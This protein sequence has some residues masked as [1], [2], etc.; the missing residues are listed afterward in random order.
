MNSSRFSSQRQSRLFRC[1]AWLQIALQFIFPLLSAT[2][3]MAMAQS[4]TNTTSPPQN[5]QPLPYSTTLNSAALALTSGDGGG[6]AGMAES[7]A[8]GYASSSVQQWLSQF[9][10]AHVQ[11]NVDDNGNWDNSAFDFLAP[12]YD[13]Q[14][15]VLFT[16]LGLRAPDGRITGNV[17]MG[18]RTF[19]T[20]NWMFGGN[21]FFDDDFTGKN[22]RVGVGA[23]AWT[24]NLKLSAN[25]YVGTTDWHQ[26]RDFDDYNEKP[27]DGYDVRAEGYLPAYPQLGAKVMYEQYYGDQVAL[28][29]KDHLQSDPSAVT[30][31]LNYTPV[32]LITAGVDYKRGQDS[33]DETR[34]TVNFRY[35]FNQTWQQQISPDQVAARRSLAGSRYDLVERNNEIVLQ[36]KQKQQDEQLSDMTLTL[37][38][39]NSP[40]DGLTANIA[41]VKAITSGGAPARNAT[42]SW[43]VTGNAKLNT[44][45]SVTDANGEASVSVTNQSAEQVVVQATSGTVT[46]TTTTTFTQSVATMDLQ[47]KKNNSLANGTD[48]NEGLVTVK[49]ASGQVMS[50]VP[51]TWKVDNGATLVSSDAQTNAR[52]Q[53]SAHFA[54]SRVGPVTLTA[55]ASGTTASVKSAFV[56]TT[57]ASVDVSM[58][59][60]NAPAD[61]SSVDEVQAVVKDAAGNPVPNVSL[62]WSLSGSQTAFMDS[63]A[64]VTTDASGFALLRLK[65]TIAESVNVSAKAGTASGSTQATFSA[66]A[67]SDIVVSITNNNAPAN[68]KAT[69][70]AQVVVNDAQG[71]PVSGV[72]VN[73][74]LSGS[75][76]A[77]A[78]SPDSAT[79]NAS[80]IATFSLVDTVAEGVTVTAEANGQQAKA[81][82]TFVAP[83]SAI[84]VSVTTNNSPADGT[85][86]NTVQAIVTDSSGQP[87]ANIPL[88][89]SLNGSPTAHATSPAT[90]STNAS[91]IATLTLTD[92][93]AE[94]V[95]VTAS[96]GGK[97]SQAT[98]TFADSV[99]AITLAVT[100]NNSPADGATADTVQATVTGPGGQPVANVNVTWH[101]SGSTT[102]S[103]TTPALSTTDSS[104]V[105]TL[106]LVDTTAEGVTVIADA[107]GKESQ[108]TAT[109]TRVAVKA[110]TVTM[111]TNNASADGSATDVAQALVTD[112]NN[113][114]IA[115]EPVTWNIT[116]STTAHATTPLTGTT[117]KNGMAT[118]SLT[119]IVG[120]NNITITAFA[121]GQQGQTT[122]TFIDTSFGP[123][124]VQYENLNSNMV[125]NRNTVTGGL[126]TQVLS[127]RNIQAG[128]TLH[129]HFEITGT[130]STPP[131]SEASITTLPY[132]W[133]TD[134]TVTADDVS[135]GKPIEFINPD[136]LAWIDAARGTPTLEAT[137]TVT[138]VRPS[139]LEQEV[140]TTSAPL[141][142]R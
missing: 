79:T 27:A 124:T 14:K 101:L 9:G 82:A 41:T 8:T 88:T 15:S 26:S 66:T 46:R 19:Y 25:T 23:E 131:D 6:A 119:D 100:G 110:V 97:Q 53:A 80:G 32:P 33:L 72:K 64:T 22:R 108:A 123:I 43:S 1:F 60:N 84:A 126:K 132:T 134:Y 102:A 38:K 24:D 35:T 104:G 12:L 28:F 2:P 11:L 75:S 34:F 93:V 65:D 17:G 128:D 137:T 30:F 129:L 67:A 59:V 71:H 135:S 142:T 107:G 74:T 94:N 4:S 44:A 21:V 36:Y 95:T 130:L 45:T 5:I 133:D 109:F 111:Q 116:N 136:N 114:P 89:W 115:N 122:A 90:V 18:V 29:D 103:P 10:T 63:P 68:G 98:V 105:A 83:V 55:S 16:Q 73:W 50:G 42:I 7:Y 76:T 49:D 20:A 96:S 138:V 69:D 51:V 48:Q 77:T 78:N 86:E 120:E 39:D 141:D 87:V 121:G 112:A 52:G 125:I 127:Y 47:L 106:K 81:T 13:N 113:H 57:A 85:A 3:F 31:G 99:A 40:A 56:A 91:G 140:G 58:K 37:T 61:G 62:T 139:T 92:S 54:S 118:L 70:T 117:D